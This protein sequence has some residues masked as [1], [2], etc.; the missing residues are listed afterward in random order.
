VNFLLLS[1]EVDSIAEAIAQIAI[2]GSGSSNIPQYG[3]TITLS[4]PLWEGSEIYTILFNDGAKILAPLKINNNF[5]KFIQLVPLFSN[6]LQL[7][8]IMEK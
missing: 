1:P 2:E 3:D 6:E 5:I 8:R 7:K 4:F